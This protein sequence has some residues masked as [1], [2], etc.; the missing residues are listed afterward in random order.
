[1]RLKDAL[2]SPE[3]RARIK[4]LEHIHGL[5]DFEV[6]AALQEEIPALDRVVHDYIDL[7]HKIDDLLKRESRE[8]AIPRMPPVFV[9]RMLSGEL[10][11]LSCAG[12]YAYG[13][14]IL[15]DIKTYGA[16]VSGIENATNVRSAAQKLKSALN[17]HC[18][19]SVERTEGK[20]SEMRAAHDPILDSYYEGEDIAQGFRDWLLPATTLVIGLID[21][22]GL[23]IPTKEVICNRLSGEDAEQ[24]LGDVTLLFG[25]RE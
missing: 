11:P 6:T 1:M 24:I 25:G 23:T 21:L 4:S 14:W 2:S 15:Q 16:A 17:T 20:L 5:N 9:M 12:F 8:W 7:L 22:G 10:D 18:C 19:I 3:T 13:R